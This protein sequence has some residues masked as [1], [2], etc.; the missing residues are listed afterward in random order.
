ML[1]VNEEHETEH[2]W[3]FD[4][5]IAMSEGSTRELSVALSWVDYDHISGGSSTPAAVV[6]AIVA[7]LID[8]GLLDEYADCF[9]A[10][11]AVRRVEGLLDAARSRL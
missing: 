1:T 3:A 10:S 5:A 4:V 6:R 9:D 2:G 8:R 11:R 7:E